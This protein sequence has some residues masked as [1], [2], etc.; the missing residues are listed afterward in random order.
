[1]YGSSSLDALLG[2]RPGL[3]KQSHFQYLYTHIH[4]LPPPFASL[5]ASRPWMLYWI[6]HSLDLLGVAVDQNLKNKSVP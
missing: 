5:D 1:M 2:D 6:L 4:K 3:D